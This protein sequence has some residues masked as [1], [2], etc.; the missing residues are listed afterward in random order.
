MRPNLTKA[1]AAAAKPEARRYELRDDRVT[2][3]RLI[4]HPSGVKTWS[5]RYTGRGGRDR[6]LTIG[7]YSDEEG[8]LGLDKARAEAAAAKLQTPIGGTTQ[9]PRGLRP[10]D[11]LRPGSIKPPYLKRFGA[12]TSR[13]RN[14]GSGRGG[15]PRPKQPI[16]SSKSDYGRNGANV[17]LMRSP[18]PTCGFCSRESI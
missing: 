14:R 18:R 17:A 12:S 15:N 13:T 9:P 5:R 4:V 6:R 10:A 11:L 1:T 3:L 16:T 7:T 8:G 2:G